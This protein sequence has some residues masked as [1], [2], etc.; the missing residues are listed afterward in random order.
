MI[1]QRTRP[2]SSKN[3]L[4]MA[5]KVEALADGS[6]PPG[7]ACWTREQSP[8]NLHQQLRATIAC[9]S[10]ARPRNK[11]FAT[12][13]FFRDGL[14]AKISCATNTPEEILMASRTNR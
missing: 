7:R 5:F 4:S 11:S 13:P 1:S 12:A 14:K 3:R 8:K 6:T 10:N 2:P 9:W